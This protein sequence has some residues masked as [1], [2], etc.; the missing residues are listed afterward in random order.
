[1]RLVVLR[2]FAHAVAATAVVA[3]LFP[4]SAPTATAS[5]TE[6]DTPPP[7][8]QGAILQGFDLGQFGYEAAEFFIDGDARSY[9]NSDATP[10][11]LPQDG[12][13]TVAA[14]GTTAPFRTRFH[15]LKPAD[16]SRFNGTVYV[17]W[18]NVSAGFDAPP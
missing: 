15:V 8:G 9:H 2:R 10:S 16:A 18:F 5:V 12:M 17:E 6:A 14:D 13:W 11:P 3:L 7:E 1:M 4:A